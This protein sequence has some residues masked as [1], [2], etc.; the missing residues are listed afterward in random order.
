MVCGRGEKAG[1]KT[2]SS[3][4][5]ISIT[6]KVHRNS[7]GVWE[8]GRDQTRMLCKMKRGWPGD[9]NVRIWKTPSGSVA[10][11]TAAFLQ[12]WAGA[13]QELPCSSHRFR[14]AEAQPR[15]LWPNRWTHSKDVSPKTQG[16][17]PKNARQLRSSSFII[18]QRK[19]SWQTP[20]WLGALHLREQTSSRSTADVGCS[21]AAAAGGAHTVCLLVNSH[22]SVFK[23]R[24]IFSCKF[25]CR[26][27]T[28]REKKKTLFWLFYS[29]G[30]CTAKDPMGT[31]VCHAPPQDRRGGEGR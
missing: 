25:C 1:E 2:P 19:W 28:H 12:L 9:H 3:S 10:L 29:E 23:E 4:R 24:L 15:N 27:M 20:N 5:S 26:T 22:S 30:I 6:D 17:F 31:A 21:Q 16:I 14:S 11:S 18:F 7:D 13:G 8:V